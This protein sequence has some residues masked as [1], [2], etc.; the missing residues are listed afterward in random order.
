MIGNERFRSPKVLLKSN[1]NGLELDSIADS[2]FQAV[3]KIV[4][5]TCK[6]LYANI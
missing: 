5:D 4:V 3:M 6:D 2:T 1:L